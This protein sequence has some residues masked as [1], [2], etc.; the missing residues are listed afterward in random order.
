M[1][2]FEN[3][4]EIDPIPA[5]QP[6][7]PEIDAELED[8]D[9]DADFE[10]MEETFSDLPEGDYVTLRF[11]ANAPR[12]AP[13]YEGENTINVRTALERAG[14]T[15]GAVNIYVDSAIVNFDTALASGTVVTLV[16]NV[17]GGVA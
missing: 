10:A 5:E 12:Y 14:L 9:F 1:N 4:N 15:V 6:I 13:I 11:G 8:D 16:G 17:K 2:Q 7:E 3:E